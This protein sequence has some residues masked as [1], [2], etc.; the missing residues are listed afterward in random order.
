MIKNTFL[1]AVIL[2][3]TM[4]TA[5]S[6]TA[7]A[8]T[9]GDGSVN[10][11]YEIE[12][13]DNLYW[14]SVSDSVWDK[15]FTQIA[16]IDALQTINWDTNKGFNPIGRD[17]TFF[18][19]KYNGKGHV[20]SRLTIDRS[21]YGVG[22]FGATSSAT[23]DSL[24]LTNVNFNGDNYVGGLVGY[25][26]LYT[27]ISNC[28]T[29]GTIR[30]D[31]CIG[32]LVGY[33]Y[34]YT[35]ISN[36]FTTG[37]T[38]GE[39][40]I[41]G[42]VGK[43]NDH[44]SVSSSSSQCDV[45]CFSLNGGGLIG[46]LYNYS[47][48]NMC[49]STGSVL[50][51]KRIGGFVGKCDYYAEI[52]NCYSSGIVSAYDDGMRIGGFVG[53]NENYSIISNSYLSGSNSFDG[54][55]YVGPFYGENTSDIYN[56]FYITDNSKAIN[57][58]GVFWKN[59]SEM[60]EMC[61]YVDG[62]LASWDFID[63]SSNGVDDIWGIN[64]N[65]NGGYPFLKFQGFA[66]TGICCSVYDPILPEIPTLSDVSDECSATITNIPTTTDN[67]SGTI[68]GTTTD[69]LTYNALGTHIVTWTFTDESGNSVTATQNVIITE[70]I[71]NPTITCA[72]N[73][74]VPAN[75]YHVY[76]VN[77]TELDPIE[78]N[79]NCTIA[80]VTND[81]SNSNSLTNQLL[82]EGM[83][84]ITWTIIDGNSNE[85]TCSTVVTVETY[86]GINDI[87]NNNI[88]IYPNPTSNFIQIK[89]LQTKAN[90]INI[91]DIT[92][93]IVKLVDSNSQNIKIDV[94]TLEKGI[95][96]VKI[97]ETVTRFV[98]K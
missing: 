72:G 2:L 59:S 11:P 94:S 4:A 55:N 43:T 60:Q 51:Y 16:D 23:I 22:F 74:T 77:G 46:K 5:I 64:I 8:P 42:L 35:S 40:N 12:T 28:F 54:I 50:G 96:I 44:C 21:I 71:T 73:K 85:T 75:Q 41:G 38:R 78:T 53:I 68:T 76:V 48:V 17:S 24:G 79:D 49:F 25:A 39:I 36:C 26:Y 97:G 32:G 83:N 20:I 84:V 65:E 87:E 89:N 6:Q 56:S 61:L 91:L 45:R 15:H 58:N 90:T 19:G 34:L 31:D 93:K 9:N 13:L 69:P 95:Y 33:A 88:S 67:C 10:N 3:V 47:T 1:T 81:I 66:H 98:K 7:T 14:L 29:T 80:S 82:D 57:E 27:S 18:T 37:S 86:T 62:T 30:G 63:E 52:H 70:D 92:G